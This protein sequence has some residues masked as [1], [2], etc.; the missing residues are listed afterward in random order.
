M[1]IYPEKLYYVLVKT[2]GGHVGLVGLA[3]GIGHDTGMCDVAYYKTGQGDVEWNVNNRYT[4]IGSLGSDGQP[5]NFKPY[6]GF[7]NP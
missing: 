2:R 5:A 6:V 7:R 1:T 4:S 3:N